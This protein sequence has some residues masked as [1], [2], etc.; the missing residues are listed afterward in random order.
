MTKIHAH[1][2]SAPKVM[3]LRAQLDMAGKV[4]V[5]VA[6][7]AAITIVIIVSGGTATPIISGAFTAKQLAELSAFI[8][9]AASAGPRLLGK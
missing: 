6:V 1:Y 7:A 9:A 3:R 5:V 2:K 8:T 4:S